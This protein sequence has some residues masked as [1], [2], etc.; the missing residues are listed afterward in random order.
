M[1]STFLEHDANAANGYR[2]S[3]GQPGANLIPLFI[4][5]RDGQVIYGVAGN[6][7]QHA[8]RG[9][10]SYTDNIYKKRRTLCDSALGILMLDNPKFMQKAATKMNAGIRSYFKPTVGKLLE[11]AKTMVL[12][13]ARHI[14]NPTSY[15]RF[16]ASDTTKDNNKTSVFYENYIRRW[17]NELDGED[18]A[19]MM[20]LY[21]IFVSCYCRAEKAK[22]NRDYPT[23]PDNHLRSSKAY[24]LHLGF[25]EA[26]YDDPAQRGRVSK[27]YGGESSAPG[28]LPDQL[29]LMPGRLKSLKRAGVSNDGKGKPRVYQKRSRG[30][31]R[32]Q[33]D[34]NVL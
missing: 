26:W 6:N 34:T 11:G 32:N 18:I 10:Y 22:R 29:G 3:M 28:L 16:S 27:P 15:G 8:P 31:D 25:R 4:T 12:R 5:R 24:S 20:S 30:I 23:L 21:D 19:Q 17:I 13:D 33:K 14:A 7:N 1:P 9:S 2:V